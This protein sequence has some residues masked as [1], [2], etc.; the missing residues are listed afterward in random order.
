HKCM[1][2]GKYFTSLSRLKAHNVVHTGEKPYKCKFCGKVF[3]FLSCKKRHEKIHMQK[4]ISHSCVVCLQTFKSTWA[5]QNHMTVH[6]RL[7]PTRCDFCDK[8]FAHVADLI[9]H[10]LQHCELGS[11]QGIEK[12]SKSLEERA[13]PFSCEECGC[14]FPAKSHLV[15]HMVVHTKEQPFSCHVCSRK[16]SFASCLRRHLIRRSRGYNPSGSKH[17]R[18]DVCGKQ[19]LSA[20]YLS[21][22]SALHTGDMP[23]ICECCGASFT[24]FNALQKHQ[25]QT[26]CGASGGQ[27]TCKFCDE[28][29]ESLRELRIH[30]STKLGARF[31]CN[32]CS[33]K[34]SSCYR[35]QRHQALC[36]LGKAVI[37][38][39]CEVCGKHFSNASNLKEHMITHTGE[40]PFACGQ[41]GRR[42]GHMA[43]LRRHLSVHGG[44]LPFKCKVCDKGFTIASALKKHEDS[45][46]DLKS[47]QVFKCEECG[48]G[49]VTRQRLKRH[50]YLHKEEKPLK[51]EF[52]GKVFVRKRSLQQH[53]LTHGETKAFKCHVCSKEYA[54]ESSLWSH[55]KSHDEGG[56]ERHTCFVC[57]KS[58]ID[59]SYL[60][61]HMLTHTSGTMP[62]ICNLCSKGFLLPA[63]LKRHRR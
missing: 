35:V 56:K 55:L 12:D 43:A 29:F 34:F 2:C 32:K 25:T 7:K 5:L 16:F 30:N 54:Y 1:P 52:C 17:F 39:I 44:D 24:H 42:F 20:L 59:K 26:S 63:G 21:N 31:T 19:F 41:C 37:P 13:K 8:I 62:Y 18:C 40:K 23:V 49:F 51:C 6:L 61:K 48:K 58:Y 27:F 50:S 22:H 53:V 38:N 10:K 47:R 45:H 14:Q 33:V 15:A 4:K 60:K 57:H 46:L 11:A 9:E 36:Q 3:S 28:K